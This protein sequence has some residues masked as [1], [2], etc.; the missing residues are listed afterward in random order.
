MT[1]AADINFEHLGNICGHCS[2]IMLATKA[3]S[4]VNEIFVFF[5]Y[6]SHKAARVDAFCI[7]GVMDVCVCV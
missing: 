1:K 3:A 4:T 5:V 2:F 6:E 7:V